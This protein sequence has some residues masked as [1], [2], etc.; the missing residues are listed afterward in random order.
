MNSYERY[1]AVYDE[2]G[3]KKL[4]RVPTHVQYIREKFIVKN[5]EILLKNYQGK[6]FNDL[7]FDIPMILGFDSIFA[8]FPQSFKFKSIKID[9]GEGK[10]VK[11]GL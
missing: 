6:L 10:S 9:I 4:D 8:P 1:V 5:K 2:S 11:I 7:Y 3:R